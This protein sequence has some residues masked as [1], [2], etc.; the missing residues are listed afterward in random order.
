[1]TF[2]KFIWRTYLFYER[3]FNA[4]LIHKYTFFKSRIE[5]GFRISCSDEVLG[6]AWARGKKHFLT[7]VYESTWDRK[8]TNVEDLLQYNIYILYLGNKFTFL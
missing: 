6:F 5:V 3:I 1:M 7:D 8:L 2:L 4:S